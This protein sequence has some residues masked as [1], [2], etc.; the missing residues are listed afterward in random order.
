[1][2]ARRLKISSIVG[3]AL[4]SGAM[5]APRARTAY[6]SSFILSCG[7]YFACVARGAADVAVVLDG[8]S[9]AHAHVYD[10]HGALS[11]GA[12]SR[13]LWDYD[14]PYRSHILDYLFKPGFGASLHMLKVSKRSASRSCARRSGGVSLVV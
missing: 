2:I 7:L 14:E 1:M 5:L 12:S 3:I 6:L 8:A 4:C 13:L 10:G 11:A 9:V